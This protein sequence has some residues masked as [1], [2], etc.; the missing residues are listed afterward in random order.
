MLA[1][2]L[3]LGQRLELNDFHPAGEGVA[4]MGEQQQIRGPGEKETSGAAVLIYRDLEGAEQS[5]CALDLVEDHR[6]WERCDKAGRIAARGCE[7]RLFV[8][9]DVGER[10][11]EGTGQGAF[12][13]LARSKEA[14][15]GCVGQR[16]F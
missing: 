15:D 9:A 14:N 12:P 7:E 5:W 6:I 10:R 11:R 2:L 8:E 16:R 3:R 4:K 1:L 13:A